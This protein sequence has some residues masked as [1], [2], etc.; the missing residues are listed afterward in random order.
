MRAYLSTLLILLSFCVIGCAPSVSGSVFFD[1]DQDGKHDNPSHGV[2]GLPV[3]LYLIA[4]KSSSSS[5]SRLVTGTTSAKVTPV[6]KATNLAK[7]TIVPETT[8]ESDDSKT[9]TPTT[10]T[11]T[12]PTTQSTPSAENTAIINAKPKGSLVE[13]RRTNKRG[14]FM[15]S[16]LEPGEY[17]VRLAD[18]AF[19]K[20]YRLTSGSNLVTV[21]AFFKGGVANFGVFRQGLEVVLSECPET[22]P[23]PQP[24]ICQTTFKNTAPSAMQNVKVSVKIPKAVM[25]DAKNGGVYNKVKNIIEWK[26]DSVESD[27]TVIVG[28]VIVPEYPV[29]SETPFLANWHLQTGSGDNIDEMSGSLS[30]TVSAKSNYKFSLEGPEKALPGEHL[31]YTAS[32]KNSGTIPVNDAL[33]KVLLPKGT[34]YVGAED[35]GVYNESEHSITWKSETFSGGTTRKHLFAVKAPSLIKENTILNFSLSILTSELSELYN[36]IV[37]LTR[38]PGTADVQLTVKASP[39]VGLSGIDT[40]KWTIVV[41]I[42]GEGKIKDAILLANIDPNL[43]LDSS[44]SNQGV[45]DSELHTLTWELGDIVAGDDSKVIL[46]AGK[47]AEVGGLQNIRMKFTL[48]G[49]GMNKEIIKQADVQA[50]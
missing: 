31:V 34:L 40:F 37:Q 9:E 32:F 3:E 20:G 26:W 48:S 19:D 43:I 47:A 10:E 29:A 6:T 50:K 17:E 5:S 15:F 41:K 16:N 38:L 12:T 11:P 22:V 21:K 4:K 45:F 35:E 1:V 30:S 36:E 7:E 28:F 13:T 18:S 8:D 49:K 39:L 2:Q 46:L 33:L 42:A 24:L 14:E 23:F 25:V 27:Q 44:T